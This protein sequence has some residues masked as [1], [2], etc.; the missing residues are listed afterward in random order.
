MEPYVIYKLTN[1]Q[2]GKSYVGK[3]KNLAARLR[4]H[5]TDNHCVLLH[6]AILKYGF[7][8]FDIKILHECKSEDE[9]FQREAECITS[10]KTLKPNGYNLLPCDGPERRLSVDSLKKLARTLQGR[11]ITNKSTSSFLG[12]CKSSGCKQFTA[13]IRFHGKRYSKG[14]MS[15]SEAAEAYDKAAVLFYG[16]TARVN[17][18]D[19]LSDYLKQ[20][21]NAFI[22][23]FSVA[24]SRLPEFNQTC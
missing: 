7:D 20:D 18:P 1:K 5:K 12:V 9:A 13:K 6:Y 24:H 22:A 21:L 8:A 11:V 10:L 3:T 23:S 14:R 17:F 19:K 16:P 15:E 4:K 2:S